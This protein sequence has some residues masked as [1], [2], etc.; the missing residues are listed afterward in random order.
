MNEK[1]KNFFLIELAFQNDELDDGPTPEDF[2]D[3]LLSLIP[4]V[5][6][7]AA[8]PGTDFGDCLLQPPT[9]VNIGD[10][11]TVKFVSIECKKRD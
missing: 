2:S 9:S 1:R 6:F 7:D 3:R 8:G 4:P 10:T 11:V 5:L